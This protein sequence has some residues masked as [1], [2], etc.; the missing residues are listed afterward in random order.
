MTK[1]Q[2]IQIFL[3]FGNPQGTRVAEITT[4]TV[5]V[6]DIP[7]K[8]LPE[9]L[10]MPE[11][12]QV[13][14]YFLFSEVDNEENISCYV[15]QSGEVGKRLQQHHQKKDFWHRA[16]VAVSLTNT[17]T[18]TH[19]KYLEWASI[20]LGLDSGRYQLENGNSGSKPHTPAPLEADCVEILETIRV[21]MSTLGYPVLEPLPSH[22]KEIQSTIYLCT[23]RG[24]NARGI[25]SSEGFTV[26][27]GSTC[28]MKP[29]AKATPQSIKTRRQ[30]LIDSG[31]L[32]MSSDT[33]VF[34]KDHLFQSPSGAS[35]SVI[36]RTSNGWR[37]W[38]TAEGVDL[39]T[40]EE[41]NIIQSN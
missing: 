36:Y 35:C 30:K 39:A 27:K 6:F 29:T 19:A 15:G 33:L 7:R 24:A 16:I 9:F 41:K 34:A 25:L 21:L 23:A 38:K 4:R 17:I 3:P 18:D 13:G 12:S 32:I 37:D 26:L 2:T 1:P 11:S 5:R 8:L 22:T 10:N 40:S 20:R 28:A 14:L 31:V